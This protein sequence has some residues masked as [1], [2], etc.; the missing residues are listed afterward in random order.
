MHPHLKQSPLSPDSVSDWV[1][2]CA[3]IGCGYL[4]ISSRGLLCVSSEIVTVW[5][6]QSIVLKPLQKRNHVFCYLPKSLDVANV[7]FY[8]TTVLVGCFMTWLFEKSQFI[9]L[10]SRKI[11][12]FFLFFYIMLLCAKIYVCFTW[13]NNCLYPLAPLISILEKNCFCLPNLTT[14]SHLLT[15]HMIF[16]CF[17]CYRIISVTVFCACTDWEFCL[18]FPPT[19]RVKKALPFGFSLKFGVA[20]CQLQSLNCFAI[21]LPT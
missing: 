3:K 13:I 14:A 20:D 16:C 15:F 8:V 1:F 19:P 10:E 11:C 9:S 7:L 18:Q 17:L 4:L 2:D 12:L 21:K 6:L 5:A